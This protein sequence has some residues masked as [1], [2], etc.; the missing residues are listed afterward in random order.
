MR[1][2]EAARQ[3]GVSPDTLKRWL[4][5]YREYFTPSA[6][7]LSGRSRHLAPHD[8]RLA[9]YIAQLRNADLSLQDIETR[10]EEARAN[11]WQ[12]LP[13]LPAQGA[14]NIPSDVAAARARD[15]VENALLSREL[16]HARDRLQALEGELTTV[17]ETEQ[18]QAGR[19]HELELALEQARGQVAELQARL[20]GF[21]LA[22]G[23]S[24]SPAALVLITLAA[25]ALLMLVAF[26]ALRLVG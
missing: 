6:T 7:P 13:A 11:D 17:R 15:M 5:Q 25:G 4:K 8:Q 20:S 12:D 24:L 10:L 26:V 21:S 23:R 16:A 1:P 3:A 18:Q 2:A 22:G 9:M 14:E 19:I